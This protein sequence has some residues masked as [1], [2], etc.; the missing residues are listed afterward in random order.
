MCL[1]KHSYI[2]TTMCRVCLCRHFVTVGAWTFSSFP[3]SCLTFSGG[4]AP[5]VARRRA[6]RRCDACNLV[7]SDQ[8]ARIPAT[9][10]AAFLPSHLRSI[11][12]REPAAGVVVMDFGVYF[13]WWFI[14]SCCCVTCFVVTFV[15]LSF[16][17]FLCVDKLSVRVG[18]NCV[19]CEYVV[20]LFIQ[21]LLKQQCWQ[22]CYVTGH[23]DA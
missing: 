13:K 10:C 3:P 1:V 8:I 21:C 6:E 12:D 7:V 14:L 5:G 20:Y 17:R 11:T 16:L 23:C 18:V 22:L 15:S 4:R 19:G 9:F 2:V